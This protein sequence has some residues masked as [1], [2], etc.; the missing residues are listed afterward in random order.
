MY[1]Y[2]KMDLILSTYQQQIYLLSHVKSIHE[3]SMSRE[4]FPWELGDIS[5]L[6]N[7]TSMVL[8]EQHESLDIMLQIIKTKYLL[9]AITDTDSFKAF[10]ATV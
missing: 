3:L 4:P 7:Q 5:G 6:I 9:V 10:N 2:V 8:N 1:M